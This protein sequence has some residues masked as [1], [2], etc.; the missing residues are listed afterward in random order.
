M[1]SQCD[2]SWAFEI[3]TVCVRGGDPEPSPPWPC[4][5]KFCTF[6]VFC[7][8]VDDTFL[9]IRFLKRHVLPSSINLCM[10]EFDHFFSSIWPWPGLALLLSLWVLL[11]FKIT[12]TSSKAA[13]FNFDTNDFHR[14]LFG[15]QTTRK[16]SQVERNLGWNLI[17]RTSTNLSQASASHNKP[18]QVDSSQTRCKHAQAKN[19]YPPTIR[20][21]LTYSHVN[22][23]GYK[24][25][26]CR[27]SASRMVL[28]LGSSPLSCKQAL[29]NT[30]FTH[31]R[32]NK[33][34]MRIQTIW[35]IKASR[36][37][38]NLYDEFGKPVASC[39][40]LISKLVCYFHG[41][42]LE[43]VAVKLSDMAASFFCPRY[44][45]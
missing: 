16:S 28:L 33:Q 24:Y 4:H 11:W 32:Y 35:W 37:S 7:R 44:H 22:R 42:I 5:C 18:S 31:K 15:V 13:M 25:N 9:I 8:F 10:S 6:Y 19:L 43:F 40:G 38:A 14:L 2:V 21:K 30:S 41:N 1:S 26:H 39:L 20:L 17:I 34:E 27:S 29:T 12:S 3:Y 23:T 36:L 45:Q